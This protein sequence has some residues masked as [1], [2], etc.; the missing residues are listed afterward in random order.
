M[1]YTLLSPGRPR[2]RDL[3]VCTHPLRALTRLTHANEDPCHSQTTA[4]PRL[5]LPHLQRPG[6]LPLPR[7]R[8]H[9]GRPR[10]Q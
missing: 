3:Q 10:V 7:Q 1:P 6:P 8:L 9:Q 5:R 2:A 4:P